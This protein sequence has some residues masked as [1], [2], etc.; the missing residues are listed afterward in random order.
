MET[1][2]NCFKQHI[3]LGGCV[4]EENNSSWY[5]LEDTLYFFLYHPNLFP[6]FMS[7][8]I[9]FKLN[10]KELVQ[11]KLSVGRVDVE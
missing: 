10:Y 1:H 4:R 3:W 11:A 7:Q 5:G 8:V 9:R 2:Q 6:I